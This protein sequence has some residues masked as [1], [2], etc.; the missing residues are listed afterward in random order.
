MAPETIVA[1]RHVGIKRK[2]DNTILM[3][4]L[5]TPASNFLSPLNHH[6]NPPSKKT[7]NWQG[8]V[9]GE[10]FAAIPIS[11]VCR[12]EAPLEYQHTSLRYSDGG[13]LIRNCLLLGHRL[14][15]SDE[16]DWKIGYHHTE[17]KSVKVYPSG[18]RNQA[19]DT[20]HTVRCP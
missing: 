13:Y 14:T 2:T 6:T 18:G 3:D 10:G 7:N 4:H 19:V 15:T 9:K 16:E 8:R 20:W 11:S 12:H 17:K 1:W 5:L